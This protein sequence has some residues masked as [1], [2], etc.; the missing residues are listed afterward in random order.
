MRFAITMTILMFVGAFNASAG[1]C[2]QDCDD[3]I[4]VKRPDSLPSN[5]IRVLNKSNEDVLEILI[6]MSLEIN[7]LVLNPMD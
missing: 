3:K 7:H 2:F 1:T 4:F 5:P 6:L